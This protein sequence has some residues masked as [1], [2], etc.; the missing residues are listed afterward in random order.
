MGPKA[1]AVV[2]AGGSGTRLWPLSTPER[3]KQF[4]VFNKKSLI[5]ETVARLAPLFPP[6]RI[7]IVARGEQEGLIQEHLP[8]IPPGNIIKE[9]LARDTAPSIGL[10][11]LF[12]KKI[13]PSAIMVV[14][15]SD[16][17]I[18]K[19]ESFCQALTL[20][21]EAAREEYLV[22]LGIVPARPATGYGYIEVGEALPLYRDG[23]RAYHVRKFIE[24]P[25]LREAKEFLR[26]GN[27]YWNSG[28]FI[29]KVERILEELEKYMPELYRGL[30]RLEG[31]WK[32]LN[33]EVLLEVY[34]EQEAVSI[35]YGVMERTS[36]LV[37]IPVEMG[38][39]DLGD[40]D[41]LNA[42]FRKD[43]KGNLI[44]ARHIGI[45]L[46]DSTI[47]SMQDRLIAT[48]GLKNIVI[49]DT[50]EVLLVM[51][52]RRAQEVKDIVAKLKR[53]QV[54]NTRRSALGR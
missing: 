39:H 7:Y 35:S 46:Q 9:P 13:D 49:V 43:E 28:I 52:R 22:T 31:H 19:T 24:K 21:I 5:Q 8:E 23:L 37:V 11:A 2:L 53:E 10:A 42:A 14:I 47:F 1:F 54:S 26:M 3:P 33:S 20:G 45:D 36:R 44:R 34:Q 50:P 40:W 38:W 17:F 12:L 27:Y 41:S 51:N 15:P 48:I 6:E 16:H 25:S 18:E 30:K 32:T 29:F 4:L